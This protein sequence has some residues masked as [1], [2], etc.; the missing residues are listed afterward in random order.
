VEG[1]YDPLGYT[2]N[3]VLQGMS[4]DLANAIGELLGWEIL[5]LPIGSDE[6]SAHLVSGNVD[7]ALGFDASLVSASKFSVGPTYLK[8]DIV[9]AVRSESE[10]KR[11]RDL[12]DCRVG[13]VNDPAVL[14]A[15]RASEH[16]TKYASGATQYLSTDRCVNALD[17][18]WCAAIVMDSLM[19]SFYREH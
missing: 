9:V 15:V 12:R 4:V 1:D 11:L 19:L 5:I 14:T 17:N 18:G 6:I 13:V 2:E 16:L 8:S 3:G 10:I 7:C